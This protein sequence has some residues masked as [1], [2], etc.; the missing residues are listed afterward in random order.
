M[1]DADRRWPKFEWVEAKTGGHGN[2]GYLK[3]CDQWNSGSSHTMTCYWRSGDDLIYSETYR[4]NDGGA[5]C[6]VSSFVP[7]AR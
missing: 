4:W 1:E 2:G 7:G 3:K 5:D 6:S